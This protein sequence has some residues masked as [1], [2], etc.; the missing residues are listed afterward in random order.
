MP[1]PIMRG[2]PLP[3]PQGIAFDFDKR[4]GLTV[5]K[6]LIG[7]LAAMLGYSAQLQAAG[8]AHTFSQDESRAEIVITSSRLNESDPAEDRPVD[9]WDI[10]GTTQILDLFEHP[11]SLGIEKRNP[12]VLGF[13]KNSVKEYQD[14][15]TVGAFTF[16]VSLGTAQDN[17][18]ARQLFNRLVRGGTGFKKESYKVVHNQSIPDIYAANIVD[19]NVLKIYSFAKLKEEIT[20][21]GLTTPC[22]GRLIAKIDA[23]A[24]DIVPDSNDYDASDYFWGWLK[25]PSSER[26]VADNKIQIA[27]EWELELWSLFEYESYV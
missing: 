11:K 9:E 24:A 7:P 3:I 6:P 22:P 16:S 2:N 13:I 15:A 5:S 8:I 19:S 21:A 25:S 20:A 12:G 18:W 26:G 27:T 4:T 23:I 14:Q 17:T 1:T 10:P